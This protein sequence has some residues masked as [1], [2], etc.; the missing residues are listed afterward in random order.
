MIF[1]I[2]RGARPKIEGGGGGG[3]DFFFFFLN[4]AFCQS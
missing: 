3:G 4:R 1:Y 2:T